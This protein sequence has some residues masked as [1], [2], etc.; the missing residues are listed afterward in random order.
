MD[1][2]TVRF[3]PGAVIIDQTP[4]Y[5]YFEVDC[6]Q[7]QTEKFVT[8]LMKLLGYQAENNTPATEDEIVVK[9]VKKVE[10]S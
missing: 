9:Y 4:G 5:G 3:V 2:V 8:N 7:Y 10:K 6:N 1:E